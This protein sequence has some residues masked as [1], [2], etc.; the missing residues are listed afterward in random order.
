MALFHTHLCSTPATSQSFYKQ[1]SPYSAHHKTVD[2]PLTGTE[3]ETAKGKE[4]RCI[5]DG[6]TG[7]VMKRRCVS[8]TLRDMQSHIQSRG[9]KKKTTCF[10]SPKDCLQQ[11]TKKTEEEKDKNV[12]C[13]QTF[14]LT[15]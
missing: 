5:N 11:G 10:L 6:R 9:W 12:L 1:L 15:L 7:A 8:L 2:K 14:P 3:T 4:Q 13:S